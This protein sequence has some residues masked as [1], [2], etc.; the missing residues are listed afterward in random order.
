MDSNIYNHKVKLLFECAV[1]AVL[2]AETDE[3][4]FLF[5]LWYIKQNGGINNLVNI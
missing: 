2:G 3:V 5:F 4:S 1:R